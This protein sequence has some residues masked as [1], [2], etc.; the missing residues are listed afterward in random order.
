M[1]YPDIPHFGFPFGRNDSGKVTVT[2]QGTLDHIRAQESAV[3]VTPLGF[4]D[5]RPDFGWEFSELLFSSLPL[6]LAALAD[7]LRRFVPDSNADLTEWAATI[8][9]WGD[10]ASIATR[11]VRIE[12][13]G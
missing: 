4:R 10:Q 5:D 9:E 3:V 11:H 13:Q 2:E 1:A 7:A 6:N 8:E 12:E